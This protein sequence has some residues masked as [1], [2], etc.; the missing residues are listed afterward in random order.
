MTNKAEWLLEQ[1]EELDSAISR[2]VDALSQAESKH[3]SADLWARIHRKTAARLEL[4]GHLPGPPPQGLEFQT[5]TVPPQDRFIPGLNS[6]TPFLCPSTQ[7]PGA[8]PPTRSAPLARIKE[9][10]Q[11]HAKSKS[12]IGADRP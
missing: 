2:D 7:A 12:K 5:E 9:I 6:R 3:A 10:K 4:C 1:I 8:L 11:T